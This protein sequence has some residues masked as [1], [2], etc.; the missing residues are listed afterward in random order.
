LGTANDFART[1]GV[2][3]DLDAACAIIGAGHTVAVDVGV[4][5]GRHFLNVASIG[6]PATVSTVL[7]DELKARWGVVAYPIAAIRAALRQRPFTATLTIDGRRRRVRRVMQVAIGSGRYFGGGLSVTAAAD[8]TDGYLN[9][10]VITAPNVGSLL[11]T[12]RHLRSG[13]YAPGDSAL[14]FRAR[15]VYV[16]TRRRHRVNVDG[17]LHGHTPLEVEVHPRSL[18]VFVPDPGLSREEQATVP[19][20]RDGGASGPDT[21]GPAYGAMTSGPT[22]PQGA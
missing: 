9:V 12:L 6:L 13:R 14:R 8:A 21:G 7:T 22:R 5:N 3:Q 11:W 15:H 10:H 4:A 18:S 1:T 2:P 20:S 19:A 17:E 16:E